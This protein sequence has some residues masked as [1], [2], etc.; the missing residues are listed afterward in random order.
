MLKL[1]NFM[2]IKCGIQYWSKQFY[3]NFLDSGNAI[4]SNGKLS[5]PIKELPER[6]IPELSMIYIF[7]SYTL[8]FQTSNLFDEKYELIQ[9]YPMPGRN[10][11]ITIQ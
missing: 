11:K 3:E 7:N 1:T 6:L 10:F 2:K 4:Q 5:F 9:D 8:I